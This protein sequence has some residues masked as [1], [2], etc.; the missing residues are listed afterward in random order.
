MGVL[1]IRTVRPAPIG[2]G[3][4]ER[5]R[6]TQTSPMTSESAGLS[7]PLASP[8][9]QRNKD[10]L[11]LRCLASSPGHL[12]AYEYGPGLHDPSAYCAFQCTADN[13]IP[14]HAPS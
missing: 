5:I 11:I 13:R 2:R 12:G 4:A 6:S 14:L 7:L 3:H 8:C 1:Q 10:A 9:I